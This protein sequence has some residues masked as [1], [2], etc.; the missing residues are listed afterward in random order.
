MVLPSG[1]R[2]HVPRR[3]AHSLDEPQGGTPLR[4]QRVPGSRGRDAN[5]TYTIRLDEVGK[6]DI[7]LAGGKGAN[8]GELSRAGLPVPPGLVVTTRAYDAFVEV[9]DIKGEVVALASVPQAEDPAR[10]EEVSERIR[11]LFSG[12]RV[13]KEI[14][15]EIRAAYEEMNEDAETAVAVRSSATAE[16]LAGASF[17]GQQDTY[18]NVRG[19]E[20]LL[21]AV[22]SSWA[23][24]WTARAMA[25]RARQGIDPATVSLAVV[26]QR[27]VES[28]AA[29]VMFTANPS[30]G[31]WNEL[32][33]SASWGLGESV[34]SGT[35]TPD[36]IVVEKGSGRVLSRET[37]DK[38]VMTVY[39]EDRTAERPV[40]EAQRLEP[41]LDD[42]MAA[43]LARYGATIEH[44]YGTPQDI[45]WALVGGDFFIVQSRP[46]TALPEPMADPPTDWSVPVP[47]GTYWRAS[48]VEQMPDP[49]SP[50]FAD[51]A[52][53]SVP[54]SLD[55]LIEEL[56]G[57]GVFREGDIAFPTVNG[58]AYYYYSLGAFWRILVKT[59]AAFRLLMGSG[60]GSGVMRW[61]EYAQPRYARTVEEW[62]AKPLGDLQANE[63]L[64][65]V[66]KLLDAGT[67]YYTSVQ[68]IIPLAYLSEALFTMFYNRLVRREGDPPAQT[69]LL[70]F[71]SMP[72]R[73]EKS[74]YDLATWS[75]EHPDLARA[76]AGTPSEQILDLLGAEVPPSGVDRE[77]WREW[78]SR[79]QSH[80][81]RYGHTVYNLD[82]VN[83]VPADDPT[84]LFDTL[85]FYL[86]GAGTDP[87]ER[88]R[89]TAARRE[90]ATKAVLEQRDARRG[91][92]FGKLL[93]WAQG[94]AP[95]REDALADVGLAWPV[96][97]RMLLELGRRLV[98]AG[99]V[100]TPADVFWLRWDEM[101][102]KAASLDAG[103]KQLASLADPV[104]QRKMLWR[105]QRRVT[106]PQLLPRGTWLEVF[107]RLMPAASEEQTGDTINGVAA[108][109]GQ[110]T[111][112]ARVLSGPED[113]P[114][115]TRR[116]AG[117]RHHYPGMDVAL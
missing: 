32:T 27:M 46:I 58:Y 66:R 10:F 74:L 108:S 42:E 24:L 109:A 71:D 69:F 95:V 38:G 97:R 112:P 51:L 13:P 43:A 92:L 77:E 84:P 82:F 53:G 16:D 28:E 111:A 6:D 31:R 26:V 2:L 106:P 79:F 50:L 70:G 78:R 4:Q 113:L 41:V 23:S 34:V 63:L 47:K 9:S 115:A 91:N 94:V 62:E 72:I 76:L 96:M 104:E 55:K 36:S 83:P 40:P 116:G 61:S 93:K 7:A 48:I 60:K 39:T 110:V 75:R 19:A 11:A 56:M 87:H 67:E 44:H 100:E 86:D 90:E 102:D 37:A 14:A 117:G 101:E 1:R 15:D 21:E 5:V 20:T 8:L 54:R 12:G 85:R 3:W 29:G 45:E 57:S 33:I 99:A 103:E 68:T 65:G 64:A 59:P 22:K 52:Y 73:A 35:V 80:L 107:E 25:Y 18:L 89:A 81:D 49:L 30:N 17:A 88:Q 114:D 105:G 98:E